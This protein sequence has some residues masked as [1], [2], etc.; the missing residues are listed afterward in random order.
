MIIFGIRE[1]VVD[2]QLSAITAEKRGR[3]ENDFL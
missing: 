1:G 2:L 3:S